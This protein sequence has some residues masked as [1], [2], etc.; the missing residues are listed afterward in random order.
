M[1]YLAEIISC[2]RKARRCYKDNPDL[3]PR[4]QHHYGMEMI[5]KVRKLKR[6]AL[7]EA[8]NTRTP[9]KVLFSNL[10]YQIT[11]ET[12]DKVKR[13]LYTRSLRSKWAKDLNEALEFHYSYPTCKYHKKEPKMTRYELI[14]QLADLLCDSVD[15]K[16][17]LQMYYDDQYNWLDSL[18]KEELTDQ[19]LWILGEEVT[20]ED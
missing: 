3:S 6:D 19:A 10:G 1:S 13:Y 17:L 9:I 16:T 8:I 12:P 15:Q 20:I 18:S 14:D 7:I 2:R 4:D 5:I 11:S